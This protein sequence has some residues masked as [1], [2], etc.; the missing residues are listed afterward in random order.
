MSLGMLRLIKKHRSESR[1]EANYRSFR[2]VAGLALNETS[3]KMSNLG[4]KRTKQ[5]HSEVMFV[6]E[7]ACGRQANSLAA[8]D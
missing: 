2:V 6:V 7:L 4:T 8:S 5:L 1:R 3:G